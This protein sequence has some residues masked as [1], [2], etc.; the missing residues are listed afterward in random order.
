MKRY[1]PALFFLGLSVILPAVFG[2]SGYVLYL[3]GQVGINALAALGLNILMGLAGQVSLGHAGFL[4]IGAYTSVLLEMRLGWPFIPSLIVA[5]AVCILSGLVLGLPALRLSGFYLAVVTMAF[6]LVITQ[7]I[8]N[9]DWLTGGP[10]GI[11]NIPAPKIGPW[12]LHSDLTVYYLILAFLVLGVLAY[13]NIQGSRTG[14][15]LQAVRDHE[16]SAQAFGIHVAKYKLIAFVL[17]AAYAGLAGVLYAHQVRYINPNDFNLFLSLS[18]MAM[19]V[20]GGLGFASGALVGSLVFTVLPYFLTRLAW[21]TW[22]IQGAA[23]VAILRLAPFGLIGA[24][25]RLRIRLAKPG[26]LVRRVIRKAIRGKKL[27]R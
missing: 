19:I 7:V 13:R 12:T 23:I 16:I 15:A 27:Y 14:R 18:Y 4:A 8:T 20:I 17:S 9:L 3:L 5:L 26:L 11:R 2:F 21:L 6:G 10:H 25:V 22:V 24:W 1:A